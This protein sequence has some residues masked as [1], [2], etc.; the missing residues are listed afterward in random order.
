MVSV[1]YLTLGS[2]EDLIGELEGEYL[3]PE[4]EES[5]DRLATLEQKID[6]IKQALSKLGIVKA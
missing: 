1:E 6:T 3:K 2:T 5:A 4:E